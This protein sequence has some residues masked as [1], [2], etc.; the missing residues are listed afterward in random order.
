MPDDQ[1]TPTQSIFDLLGEQLE[2][3]TPGIIPFDYLNVQSRSLTGA[4]ADDF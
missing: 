4:S 3:S 1:R 2:L